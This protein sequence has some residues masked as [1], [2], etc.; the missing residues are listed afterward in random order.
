VKAIVTRLLADRR[1]EKVLVYDWADPPAPTANQVKTKTLFSGITNGTERNDL[2]GGNYATRDEDLPR[3][4]GYQNVGQVIAVGPQ[5]KT[6]Q[7]N[8]L[9]YMSADHTEYVVYPEDGL[10]IKLPPEVKPVEAALFGM[11]SVAMRTCRHAAVG[12]GHKVLIVGGGSLGQFAAQI[13]AVL[14]ARVTLCDLDESRLDV[15][16]QI[17]AAENVINAQ[18]WAD[19][20]PP[21]SFDVVMDF[22]GVPGMED[23]LIEAVRQRGKLMF[24]AGRRQVQYNFNLGQDHEIEIC[25]NGHF[26]NSDLEHLCWLVARGLVQVTPLLTQVV[27]A[28]QAEAIYTT[29]RDRP[30]ELFGTVFQW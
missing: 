14:G 11:A 20:A 17:G 21:F 26:D 28:A 5:T 2:V 22:A 9:L 15:A 13:A 24:I 12:L 10:L 30:A 27:P 23:Q 3:G 16:R 19:H 4:W 25:Q 29:L 1:R 7:V 18:A 6:L 8:D